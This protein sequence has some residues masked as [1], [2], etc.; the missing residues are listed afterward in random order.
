[1]S[2]S[3]QLSWLWT[4]EALLR[5]ALSLVLAVALWLYV[6]SKEN[7]SVI[8]YSQPLQITATNVGHQ[9]TVTNNLE[10]V[11]VRL[12]VPNGSQII[13]SSNLRFYVNLL[14]K[15]PG[16]YKS[17][18]VQYYADPGIKVVSITP[19]HVPVTIERLET[20]SVPVLAHVSVA[21]PTGYEAGTPQFNPNAIQVQGPASLVSQVAQASV[22]VNLAGVKSGLEGTQAPTLLDSQG[23]PVVQASRLMLIPAQ[24]GVTVAVRQL[25]S[26]KTLPVLVRIKGQPKTG[27]GVSGIS[28]QPAEI[29]ATGSPAILSRLSKAFTGYVSVAGLG[30]GTVTRSTAIRL[31][32]GVDST[33]K[34][35]NVRIQLAP[36]EV[37]T[38]IQVGVSPVGVAPGLVAR[39]TPAVVLVT[40]VG[41]S[42]RL[43]SAARNIRAT[44]NVSGYF[45]GTYSLQPTV[46]APPGLAVEEVAP[47]E[48]T[49][50]LQPAPT[51]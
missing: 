33:T 48:V 51:R 21:A 23:N 19:S 3:R 2:A 43:A 25:A 10:S 5:L 41:P 44:V 1:V 17:V 35:V 42:S 14:G 11:H 4:R 12:R 29:T 40:V 38:S 45:A 36:V 30:A 15:G 49:V 13:T 18:P 34:S 8:D 31:P 7:P 39:T 9:L 32:H 27:Y 22:D 28:I 46:L 6:T 37:S 47:T 26:F 20:R 50:N 24:V 16:S